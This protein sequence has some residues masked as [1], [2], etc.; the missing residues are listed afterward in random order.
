MINIP[1][2][3]CF[4]CKAT[5]YGIAALESRKVAPPQLHGILLMEARRAIWVKTNWD[6]AR[7]A[8]HAN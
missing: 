8:W 2:T 4:S 5:A 1:T 3:S 7:T 6:L